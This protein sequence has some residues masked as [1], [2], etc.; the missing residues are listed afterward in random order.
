VLGLLRRQLPAVVQ[1]LTQTLERLERPRD[2][3]E[4]EVD[5]RTWWE[6]LARQYRTEGVELPEPGLRPGMR[7]PQSLFN[8]VADNLIRNAL[9]KRVAEPGIRIRVLLQEHAGALVFRVEDSGSAVPGSTE[10]KLFSAP[11]PSAYGLGIGLYQA[12][13]QARSAGY[14]LQLESN[15]DGEVRFA[16]VPEPA[17]ER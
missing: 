17:V 15:R 9:A 5:A 1:R 4:A 8:S 16:L 3:Q 2:A 14:R 7:V 13:R 10:A 12:A 11:V 6:G